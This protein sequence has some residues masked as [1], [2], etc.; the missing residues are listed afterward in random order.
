MKKTKRRICII[1][2]VLFCLS[3]LFVFS[4]NSLYPILRAR[5][6]EYSRTHATRVI[7]LAVEEVI[8]EGGAEYKTLVN[9]E[10]DSEGNVLSLSANIHAINKLKSRISLKILDLLSKEQN[11]TLQIPVGNLSGVYLFSGKGFS[12]SVR[13]I[14]TDSVVTEVES[15]FSEVGINQSWHKISMK[16]TVRIGVIVLGEHITAEVSDSIVIADSVIVGKVP[17][18]YTEMER[19]EADLVGDVVDFKAG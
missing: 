8:E 1:L 10:R 7:N 12:F 6:V 9:T 11:R 4:F 14:P 19:A 15:S 3:I 16:V 17:D 18:A 5:S 13:L 2:A